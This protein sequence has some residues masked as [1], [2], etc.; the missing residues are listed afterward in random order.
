MELKYFAVKEAKKHRVSIEHIAPTLWLLTFWLK[1]Y[2]SKP[3]VKMLKVWVLLLSRHY[4]I[5]CYCLCFYIF[6]HSELMNEYLSVELVF[7]VCIHNWIWMMIIGSLFDKD[8][9]VGPIMCFL[10][11]GHVKEKANYVVHGKGYVC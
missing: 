7:K 9:I 10:F 11:T 3:L 2:H 1:G 6:W 5:L 8:F 4:C